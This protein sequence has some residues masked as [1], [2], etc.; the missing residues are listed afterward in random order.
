M[1]VR[2]VSRE[3]WREA[4]EWELRHWDRAERKYGWRRLVWPV[5]RPLLKLVGSK[6]ADGDDWNFWWRVRF[7]DYSFLPREIGDFIELGCGPYTN[8]RLISEGRVIHRAVCSDPLIHEYLRF[9][10]SWVARAY[11]GHRVLIDDHAAEDSPFAPETF[12]VVVMINVLDHVYDA[13]RAL[14]TATRLVRPG[15]YLVLGQDLTQ[16]DD[17]SRKHDEPG[18]P[19][20]I[21]REDIDPHLEGFEPLLRRD[22]SREEGRDPD[23]HYAT[24]I[25]A[26]RK[27]TAETSPGTSHL[28]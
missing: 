17:P 6:R 4:Q 25:F 23:E 24:L 27:A 22:L 7:D 12:D 19:I 1:S 8:F 20:R 18:H 11:R 15:G 26:G 5:A 9:R 21:K 13:D 3:R 16:E 28:T 2:R 10:H 14:Q